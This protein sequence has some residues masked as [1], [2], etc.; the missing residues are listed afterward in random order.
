VN[1]KVLKRIIE[2]AK[3]DAKNRLDFRFID[4]MS[5]LTSKGFLKTNLN[6]PLRPNK[7]INI[8][9]AIWAGKNVEPRILEV[10]PAAVLRLEKHF[11]LNPELHPELYK[12]ILQLKNNA[13][14]GDDFYH[15]P[16]VKLKYWVDFPL[17]DKR[18]K[19]LSKKKILKTFRLSP[20]VVKTIKRLA[21]ELG[22]T[23]VQLVERKIMDLKTN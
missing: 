23:E 15:V 7:R 9:D 5:F 20:E 4:V 22:L 17:L 21:Q 6:I 11:D 13:N 2:L 12:I 1:K 8:N 3:K 19:I 16:F 10:L 18:T 14:T